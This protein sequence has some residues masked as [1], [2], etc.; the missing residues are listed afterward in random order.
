M[1]RIARIIAALLFL[2]TAVNYLDRLALPIVSPLIRAEFHMTEQ[3]YS[4]VITLFLFAYAVMYAGS[5]YVVDRLGAKRGFAV[6]I[7]FWSA[8]SMLHGIAT[9]KWSLVVIASCS[10]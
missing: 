2:A 4:Q 1:P 8:A 3:D 7:S 6:F 9:G 10:D 5:G